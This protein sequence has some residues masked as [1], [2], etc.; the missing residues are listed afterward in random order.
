MQNLPVVY[1]LSSFTYWIA[2]ATL[3]YKKPLKYNYGLQLFVLMLVQPYFTYMSDCHDIMCNT[4]N[5][6]YY[7]RVWAIMGVCTSV[8]FILTN[9]FLSYGRLYY[10][11]G[12]SLG[13]GFW[14]C[15]AYLYQSAGSFNDYWV[16]AHTLWHVFPVLGGVAAVLSLKPI[17]NAEKN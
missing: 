9:Q 11:M 13:L 8:A 14:L 15:G 7:D 12:M 4:Q 17:E 6:R 1:I 3:L 2:A 16:W 5:W 10:G